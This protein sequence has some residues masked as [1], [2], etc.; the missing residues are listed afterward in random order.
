MS[1][2][3]LSF[4]ELPKIV[5][6]DT[7]SY[8][9]F[10]EVL[11]SQAKELGILGF[12][13]SPALYLEI[14]AQEHPFVPIQNPG[15][16]NPRAQADSAEKSYLHQI[17]M[18]ALAKYT[19]QQD[20]LSEHT[21]F[22]KSQLTPENIKALK[23]AFPAPRGIIFAT[24]LQLLDAL[25]PIYGTPSSASLDLEMEKLLQPF[26]ELTPIRSH[27]Y[28]HATTH[29][30]FFRASGEHMPNKDKIKY[31][32]DS[33]PDR[34]HCVHDKMVDDLPLLRDRTFEVFIERLCT[35][36]GNH[37]YGERNAARASG[38]GFAAAVLPATLSTDQQLADL[39]QRM[40]RMMAIQLTATTNATTSASTRPAKNFKKSKRIEHCFTHGKCTHATGLCRD[41]NAEH[42]ANYPHKG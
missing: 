26:E 35:W 13:V 14:T 22:V 16:F 8:R 36:S 30:Q 37:P 5:H 38:H 15:G 27:V 3:K 19:K 12:Y 17:Y 20:R 25:A 9:F 31:L 34:F 23:I 29:D 6:D 24:V 33:L 2:E 40:D 11:S 7:E 18:A 41:P 1:S 42:K 39:M 21:A 32:V 10:C 28:R 4:S